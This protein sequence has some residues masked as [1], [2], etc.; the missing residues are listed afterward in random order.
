MPASAAGPLSASRTGP[1]KD[2][3][4]APG[5]P[6]RVSIIKY[7]AYASICVRIRRCAYATA[8]GGSGEGR[9]IVVVQLTTV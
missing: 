1:L 6:L 3:P 9:Y 4:E 7:F 5:F 8:S 2:R